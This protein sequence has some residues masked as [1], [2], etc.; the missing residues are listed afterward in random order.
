MGESKYWIMGILALGLV[1]VTIVLAANSKPSIVVNPDQ[2]KDTITVTGTT[3]LTVDPDEVEIYIVVETTEVTAAKTKDTNAEIAEKVISALK[4]AGIKSDDIETTNYYLY[5]KYEWN[6]DLKKSE[7]VGYTLSNTMKVTT[8]D[9]EKTGDLIDVAV[10]AGAN[11]VDNVNFKLSKEM[12]K[13][14]KA[15]A[16]TKA[17]TAAKEKADALT[18]T[19]GVSLGKIK[20]ISESNYYYTPYNVRYD[21][22]MAKESAGGA[23]ATNIQPQKLDVSASVSLVYEI[24]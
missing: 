21:V 1:I 2:T 18:D 20:S 15:D 23:P 10:E 4:R 7:L 12:E 11:R 14:V 9:L 22:S 17:A 6:E 3:E 16:M 24:N 5:P 13:T 8:D 19:L